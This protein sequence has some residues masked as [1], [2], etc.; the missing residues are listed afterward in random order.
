M[1][2]CIAFLHIH[3]YVYRIYKDNKKLGSY[4][5]SVM[6]YIVYSKMRMLLYPKELRSYYVL[7]FIPTTDRERRYPE[8]QKTTAEKTSSEK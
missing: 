5:S 4:A 3:L 1:F 8:R 6:Y 7:L 2:S